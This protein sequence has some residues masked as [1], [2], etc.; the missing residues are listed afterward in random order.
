MHRLSANRVHNAEHKW[1]YIGDV[2]AL[3]CFLNMQMPSYQYTDPNY[4]D[5]YD[6]NP[7]ILKVYVGIDMEP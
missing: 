1:S 3:M 2:L 4:K 6:G 7:Y 5:L